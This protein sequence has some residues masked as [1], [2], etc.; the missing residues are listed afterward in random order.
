MT[1]MIGLNVEFCDALFIEG[2]IPMN[3][4]TTPFSSMTPPDTFKFTSQRNQ[5]AAAASENCIFPSFRGTY[6]CADQYVSDRYSKEFKPISITGKVEDSQVNANNYGY[7]YDIGSNTTNGVIGASAAEFLEESLKVVFKEFGSAK[8]DAAKFG[9]SAL[10]SDVLGEGLQSINGEQNGVLE[11]LV[12][13]IGSSAIADGVLIAAG[14]TSAPAWATALVAASIASGVSYIYYDYFGND[15]NDNNYGNDS[16]GNPHNMWGDSPSGS[17]SPSG[18]SSQDSTGHMPSSG[19]HN[20]GDQNSG[21]PTGNPYSNDGSNYTPPP[22]PDQSGC[23]GTPEDD[24][25]FCTDR[26]GNIIDNPNPEDDGT[27]GATSKPSV[28]PAPG[29]VGGKYSDLM[30]PGS[31]RGG[32]PSP[33]D[34]N[35][36][37]PFGFGPSSG[38]GGNGTG[39]GPSGPGADR[40]NEGDDYGCDPLTGGGSYGGTVEG[41]IWL[42]PRRNPPKGGGGKYGNS[43]TGFDDLYKPYPDDD[44]GV[45]GPNA[46][47]ALIDGVFKEYASAIYS[48][49]EN[50][51]LTNAE[52]YELQSGNMETL[53]T[54]SVDP[55]SFASVQMD[56]SIQAVVAH[57]EVLA[58]NSGTINKQKKRNIGYVFSITYI[59]NYSIY[60]HT[61]TYQ[62]S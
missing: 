9:I 30:N 19:G 38:G 25:I 26:D 41:Y 46:K 33:D 24:Y 16:S 20:H 53:L 45:G 58:Q 8:V 39:R 40:T 36:D 7:L 34:D 10:T 13:T 1:Q 14:L 22:K 62:I 28:G 48:S 32:R 12:V 55:T 60:M 51:S 47:D 56:S 4:I 52:T 43:G 35:G 15:S 31:E 11:D 18:G 61:I 54:S 6:T 23:N 50:S 59:Y 37:G 42:P 3:Q 21:A 49:K 29:D 17:G 57:V 44:Y 27:Q 2:E 5:A